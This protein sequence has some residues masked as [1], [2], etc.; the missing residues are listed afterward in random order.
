MQ[1]ALKKMVLPQDTDGN[2][3]SPTG[4]Y[5]YTSVPPNMRGTVLYSLSGLKRAYPE[6][7]AKALEKYQARVLAD[8]R[9][10]LDRL[11]LLEMRVEPLGGRWSDAIF[12]SENDPGGFCTE[13]CCETR[14]NRLA[15]AKSPEEADRIERR[16]REVVPSMEKDRYYR[17]PVEALADRVVV[18]A[19][20]PDGYA[21]VFALAAQDSF[22]PAGLPVSQQQKNAWREDI[23]AGRAVILYGRSPHL[24]VAAIPDGHNLNGLDISGFKIVSSVIDRNRVFDTAG[25]H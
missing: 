6:E 18:R 5:V 14:R 23:E 11:G 3:E 13:M 1:P 10:T 19:S 9:R 21:A 20:F 24:L 7:A 12:L 15:M 8:G 22:T 4:R 16:M 17:I 2:F 25:G